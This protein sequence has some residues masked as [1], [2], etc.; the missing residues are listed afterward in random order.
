[1]KHYFFDIVLLIIMFLFVNGLHTYFHESIHAH[2]CESFGGSATTKYSVLMQGGSTSCT[3]NEGRQ[4]HIINDI[5]S[6]TASII[7]I[8]IFMGMVFLSI[9]FAKKRILNHS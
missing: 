1:M 7:V 4:Y 9:L 5:V 3:T 8:T 6:Y 2:I